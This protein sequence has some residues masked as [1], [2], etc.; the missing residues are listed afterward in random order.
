MR[1]HMAAHPDFSM[2]PL[3]KRTLI[4]TPETV[5]EKTTAIPLRALYDAIQK[6]TAHAMTYR[7][8]PEQAYQFH[9]FVKNEFV[10]IELEKSKMQ[11]EN[12]TASKS[13]A[14]MATEGKIPQKLTIKS[15]PVT[16]GKSEIQTDE[17]AR[18]NQELET[19]A[20]AASK[21]SLAALQRSRRRLM[22]TIDGFDSRTEI[23]AQATKAYE[24]LCGGPGSSNTLDGKWH[25]LDERDRVFYVSDALYSIAVYDGLLEAQRRQSELQAEIIA[26]KLKREE[27][28]KK[29]SAADAI[30]ANASGEQDEK[31]LLEKF[32]E[33]MQEENKSLREELASVKKQL[34]SKNRGGGQAAR[35]GHQPYTAPHTPTRGRGRG[36]GHQPPRDNQTPTTPRGQG[37][38]SRRGRSRPSSRQPSRS[39]SRPASR[40]ASPSGSTRGHQLS[41]S[42]QAMHRPWFAPPSRIIVQTRP[43]AASS[44]TRGGGRGR[45]QH[46]PQRS[47]RN[48]F[49]GGAAIARGRGRGRGQPRGRTRSRSRSNSS[50]GAR[51]RRSKSRD[52]DS[53]NG[54]G[55]GSRS[56]AKR[57]GGRGR[58]ARGRHQSPRHPRP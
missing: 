57:N 3:N 4:H 33:M 27:E 38:N 28:E 31:T 29:R 52:A 47:P 1:D 37:G 51:S 34:Q 43:P 23:M 39:P 55:K 12:E 11:H 35:G 20:A 7:I 32:R 9:D 2:F 5:G 44:E 24:N 54:R 58:G 48:Q 25:V 13:L 30:M 19:I 53:P 16:L 36:R 6:P 26:K 14:T 40:N 15:K 42:G 21:E 41:S 22:Q 8:L 10:Q 49:Q 45:G 50:D 17:A 56:P 18:L 46:H